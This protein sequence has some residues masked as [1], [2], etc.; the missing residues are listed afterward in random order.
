M[1]ILSGVT[2]HEV[3]VKI[4]GVMSFR[5]EQALHKLESLLFQPSKDMI[6]FDLSESMMLTSQFW[7]KLTA[8]RKRLDERNCR[9]IIRGVSAGLKTVIGSMNLNDLF[10]IEDL[11]HDWETELIPI[12]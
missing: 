5:D 2:D 9:I 1:I 12:S 6:I 11:P 3:I 7:G 10:A 4:A 8:L